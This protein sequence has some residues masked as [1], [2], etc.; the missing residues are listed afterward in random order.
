MSLVALVVLRV[1]VINTSSEM[2]GPADFL[3]EILT[4][5]W[6]MLLG[7]SENKV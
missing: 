7:M 6:G 1:T 5:F 4:L 3:V 2:V